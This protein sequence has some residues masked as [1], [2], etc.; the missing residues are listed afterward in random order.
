MAR[1][2]RKM[3]DQL[4]EDA[5]GDFDEMVDEIEHGDASDQGA[6]GDDEP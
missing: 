3:G 2:M 4:G 1:W 6:D 5:G